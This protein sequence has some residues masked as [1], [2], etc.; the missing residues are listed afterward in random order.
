MMGNAPLLISKNNVSWSP[1]RFD[2]RL[3]ESLS[4]VYSLSCVA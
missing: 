2:A 1:P 3:S 4:C